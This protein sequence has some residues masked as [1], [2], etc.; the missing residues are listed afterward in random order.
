MS[1]QL[2]EISAHIASSAIFRQ[3]TVFIT[4]VERNKKIIKSEVIVQQ[5][6]ELVLVAKIYMNIFIYC[7]V[8]TDPC[9]V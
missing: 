9:V 4:A 6:N 8:K 2:P 3:D 1:V 7:K 5:Q